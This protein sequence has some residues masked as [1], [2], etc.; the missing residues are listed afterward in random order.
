MLGLDSR[1]GRRYWTGG[2]ALE[3]GEDGDGEVLTLEEPN[4]ERTEGVRMN[5]AA[6]ARR[7]VDAVRMLGS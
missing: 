5:G 2:G 1:A 7:V 4:A 3:V 6:R